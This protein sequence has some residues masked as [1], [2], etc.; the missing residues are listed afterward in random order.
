MADK[1]KELSKVSDSLET[2]RQD[3][4]IQQMALDAQQA[5]LLEQEQKMAQQQADIDAQ[6]ATAPAVQFPPLETET[7]GLTL[8]EIYEKCIPSVVSI[9]SEY[10]GGSRA[11][12]AAPKAAQQKKPQGRYKRHRPWGFLVKAIAPPS[13]H[14]YYTTLSRLRQSPLLY[15]QRTG[16][17]HG[18]GGGWGSP[19]LHRSPPRRR[20][21]ASR[22][23]LMR[24]KK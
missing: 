23:Q 21:A 19:S 15:R 14:L 24:S 2:A 20:C 8:Q 13:Q 22:R 16:P 17:P 4:D 10:R 12:S 6:Q 7:V 9:T 18:E 3:L 11:A 1:E 5:L